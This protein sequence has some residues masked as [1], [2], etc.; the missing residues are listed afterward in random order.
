[1]YLRDWPGGLR[2]SDLA[3]IADLRPNMPPLTP[4]AFDGCTCR[5]PRLNE[6]NPAQT[7]RGNAKSKYVDHGPNTP[8]AAIIS[9][10]GILN[11]F[12][13]R[14]RV[15]TMANVPTNQGIKGDVAPFGRGPLK[16]GIH[17]NPSAMIP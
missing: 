14:N 1:M 13:T 10:D 9:P 8:T 11:R 6:T 3:S 12:I 16:W 17:R 5:A 7:T 2:T 4:L 15:T